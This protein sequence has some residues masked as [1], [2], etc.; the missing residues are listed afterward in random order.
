MEMWK[1]V[2]G[3]EGLYQV[4]NEGRTRRLPSTVYNGRCFANKKGIILKQVYTR[5]NY[6]SVNFSKNN[7]QKMHRVN[8]LVAYAFIENHSNLPQVGHLNDD[9][10]NNNVLNLYWTDAKE[11]S[12]H[13]ERNIRI[14]EKNSKPIIGKLK[15][16]IIKFKSSID[17]RRNGFNDSAI[18][19]C[20][21]GIAKT[22]KGF[23]WKYDGV[24]N[25]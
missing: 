7:I 17:A 15:N 5:G 1:D 2:D 25:G 14:G 3:Y 8:R 16:E 18:R 10:E 6:L 24:L 21:T 20:L 11:N 4:S 13:N 12:T 22:H 23:T 19:N 9:K